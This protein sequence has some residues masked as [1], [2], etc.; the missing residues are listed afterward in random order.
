MNSGRIWLCLPP[1]VLCGLDG[2]LTLWGQ[3]AAYW[4]NGYQTYDEGNPLAAWLLTVHPLAFAAAGVVY[5]VGVCAAVMWLPGR[6]AVAVASLVSLG[7]TVGAAAWVIL[8]VRQ[9]GGAWILLVPACAVGAGVLWWRTGPKLGFIKCQQPCNA[10]VAVRRWF[11][12]RG[13]KSWIVGA[14]FAV[15]VVVS[16]VV[17]YV[18]PSAVDFARESLAKRDGVAPNELELVGYESSS[19]L[20]PV[21][22]STTTVEFR[23]KGAEHSKNRVVELFRV[24]YFLPWWVSAY[25]EG[26]E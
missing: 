22:M 21:V 3:P 13:G 19:P 15:L 5:C 6:Y 1:V 4:A 9:P 2:G 25:R 24:V 7:H 10:A 23:V 16:L 11:M 26:K 14:F 18:Q 8:L 12:K 17:W 20:T